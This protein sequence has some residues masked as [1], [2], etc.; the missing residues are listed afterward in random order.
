MRGVR[1]LCGGLHV[2]YNL[3]GF[4]LPNG[5]PVAAAFGVVEKGTENIRNEIVVLGS[6][7]ELLAHTLSVPLAN[8]VVALA[9]LFGV[10]NELGALAVS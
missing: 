8:Q 7:I 4:D 9:Y 1:C 3:I 10:M 5:E 2:P 6:D